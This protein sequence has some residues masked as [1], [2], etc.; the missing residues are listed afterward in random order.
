MVK[1]PA[2]A[3]ARAPARAPVRA[4]VR[5]DVDLV[6]EADRLGEA[7]HPRHTRD[8]IGHGAAA[9]AVRAAVASGRPHHGWLLTG[10]QG[11]GKA[12]FAYAMTR[13]LLAPERERD[14]AGPGALDVV[15]GSRAARQVAALSH[16]GLLLL[17]R[18]YDHKIKKFTAS[19]PVDEVRRVKGFLAHTAGGDGHRVILVDQADD[20]NTNAANAILKS[21]EEPPP[22]TTF[23]LVS[24]EPGRLLPTIRSR[25]RTLQLEALSEADLEHAVNNATLVMDGVNP[26]TKAD[27]PKLHALARG[28][29]RAAL[30]ALSGDG[31]KLL[32][33]ITDMLAKLPDVDW[34]MAHQVGDELGGA[35]NE[36]QFN[37]YFDILLDHLHGLV[38]ARV[39]GEG[40]LLELALRVVPQHKLA[41]WAEAHA[42]IT[43]ARNTTLAVNLD[44][45]TLVLR[46]IGDLAALAK[47]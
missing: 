8:V 1:A 44:R 38:R 24:S 26:P 23:I 37:A 3:P 10:R 47:D 20:L 2:K 29:V 15:E 34:A 7:A 5:Q 42:A 31:V 35:A 21:L 32:T 22:A 25:C 19:I 11:I 46:T 18:T 9:E 17:R 43:Q 30:M 45:K 27:W 28:S 40:P 6:P 14:P 13:Y 41:A 33:R 12:T 4:P 36:P 16:P 39:A